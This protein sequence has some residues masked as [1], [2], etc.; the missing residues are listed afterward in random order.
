M[1]N[2]AGFLRA[3]TDAGRTWNSLTTNPHGSGSSTTVN[4]S[5]ILAYYAGN[6]LWV[7]P[8]NSSYVR[9]STDDGTSTMTTVSLNTI[10]SLLAVYARQS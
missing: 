7:N 1:A 4:W 8:N 2:G 5:Q 6:L 3:S 10:G 9:R